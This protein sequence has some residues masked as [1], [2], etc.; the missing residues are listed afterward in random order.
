MEIKAL[1]GPLVMRVA[2]RTSA[3]RWERLSQVASQRSG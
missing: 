2:A 3:W 1:A